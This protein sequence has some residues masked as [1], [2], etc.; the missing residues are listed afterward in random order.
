MCS[1]GQSRRSDDQRPTQDA[2]RPGE[3]F[4]DAIHDVDP[5]ITADRRPADRFA[6]VGEAPL[7]LLPSV[8]ASRKKTVVVLARPEIDLCDVGAAPAGAKIRTTSQR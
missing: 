1:G 7:T 5:E 2:Q 8:V 3:R 4:V 6:A